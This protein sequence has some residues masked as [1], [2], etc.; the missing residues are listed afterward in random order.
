M[1][2]STCLAAILW[3]SSRELVIYQFLIEYKAG[4][5][6][7]FVSDFEILGNR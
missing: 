1:T 5:S 2:I 7:I 4:I 3:R 6:W